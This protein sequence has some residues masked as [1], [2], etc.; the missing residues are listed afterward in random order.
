[1]DLRP[2]PGSPPVAL[3]VTAWAPA[4]ANLRQ[5]SLGTGHRLLR[6]VTSLGGLSALRRMS[7]S[8][9]VEIDPGSTAT[10]QTLS[11]WRIAIA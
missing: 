4:L 5:L 6:L 2:G 1:M 8:G 11:S 3:Y 7:I 10:L 9:R